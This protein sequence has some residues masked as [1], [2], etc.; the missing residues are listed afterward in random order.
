MLTN[1]YFNVNQ[2]AARSAARESK[3]WYKAIV[4]WVS[5]KSNVRPSGPK[6]VAKSPPAR[7]GMSVL[8]GI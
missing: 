3:M 1:F 7:G 6:C 8:T 4:V 2:H 5:G